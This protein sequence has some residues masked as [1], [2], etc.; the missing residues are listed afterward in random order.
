M[1]NA[2]N[3]CIIKFGNLIKICG[4]KSGQEFWQ[5]LFKLDDKLHI[6]FWIQRDKIKM[7]LIGIKSVLCEYWCDE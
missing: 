3:L 1:K 2:N 6:N 7:F 4:T 5:K